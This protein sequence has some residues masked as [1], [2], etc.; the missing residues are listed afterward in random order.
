MA[1]N[2]ST[3]ATRRANCSRFMTV[4]HLFIVKKRTLVDQLHAVLKVVPARNF[5]QQHWQMYTLHTAKMAPKQ[6]CNAEAEHGAK[7]TR[8]QPE[9]RG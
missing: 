7:R 5:V 8:V 4:S 2:A 3:R 9:L 1:N 6:H